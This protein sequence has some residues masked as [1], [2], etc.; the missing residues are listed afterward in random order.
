MPLITFGKLSDNTVSIK[1]RLSEHQ[2][3]RMTSVLTEKYNIIG[4]TA[5]TEAL[6]LISYGGKYNVGPQKVTK[7]W[8]C[9]SSVGGAF[10]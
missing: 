2:S 8:A 3:S 10:K 1:E 4:A 5:Y 7:T 9:C 6:G